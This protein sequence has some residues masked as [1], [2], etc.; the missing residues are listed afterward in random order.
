MLAAAF[1]GGGLAYRTMRAMRSSVNVIFYLGEFGARPNSTVASI[2]GLPSPK[3]RRT[4]RVSM[5]SIN[6]DL[7]RRALEPS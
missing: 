5:L 7:K 6:A 3:N 4:S 2:S 1:A